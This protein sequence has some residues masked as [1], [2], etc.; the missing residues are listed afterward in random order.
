MFGDEYFVR[1]CALIEHYCVLE[2]GRRVWQEAYWIP[3]EKTAPLPVEDLILWMAVE[4]HEHMEMSWNDLSIVCQ[5][6]CKFIHIRSHW[7]F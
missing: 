3:I 7:C 5:D 4:G 6:I 1:G 2:H